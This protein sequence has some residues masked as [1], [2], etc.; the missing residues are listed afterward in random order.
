MEFIERIKSRF[1]QKSLPAHP[2]RSQGKVPR[3][4]DDAKSIGILFNATDIDRRKQVLRYADQLKKSGKTVDLLGFIEQVDKEATFSFNFYTDK[5]VDWARRPKGEDVS[6]FLTKSFDVFIC[7]FP[8]T[9]PSSEFLALHCPARLK[10]GPV[11]SRT[12][13]YDLM[14]DMPASATPKQIIQ[15][16]DAIFAKSLIK[17]TV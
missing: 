17:A 10:I 8:K 4:L 7:L 14:L 6:K 9:S 2:A 15:Q 3:T 13:C 12:D 16:Y 1:Y 11:P 5:Q